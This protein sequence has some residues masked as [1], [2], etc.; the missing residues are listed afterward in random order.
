M[1]AEWPNGASVGPLI[2]VRLSDPATR[3]VPMG[4]SWVRYQTETPPGRARRGFSHVVLLRVV[5]RAVRV[6]RESD[7]RRVGRIYTTAKFEI[8]PVDRTRGAWAIRSGAYK[9]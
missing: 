2:L 3:H 8:E 7:D 9:V 4:A 6:V 1:R 5:E